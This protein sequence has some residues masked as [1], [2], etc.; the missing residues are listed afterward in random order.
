MEIKIK[1]NVLNYVRHH[2]LN[3]NA[4]LFCVK[5]DFFCSIKKKNVLFLLD[6]KELQRQ[7]FLLF[8]C[9]REDDDEKKRTFKTLN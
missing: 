6:K 9:V 1:C 5:H 4:R 7:F 3:V 2:E 8:F